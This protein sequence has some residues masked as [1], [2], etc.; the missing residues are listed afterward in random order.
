MFHQTIP[1][2]PSRWREFLS[3]LYAMV[4]HARDKHEHGALQ[5]LIV[6][7]AKG[8][9]EGEF[10]MP[11]QSAAQA[12]REEASIAALQETLSTII[13]TRFGDPPIAIRSRIENTND[14]AQLKKW[15]TEFAL[16]Q[17]LDDIQFEPAKKKKR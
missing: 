11:W 6:E 10:T 15:F 1:G 8:D 12:A 3:Y 2:Q 13:Q 4:Y 9:D 14:L 7:S 17:T 16:A 5:N